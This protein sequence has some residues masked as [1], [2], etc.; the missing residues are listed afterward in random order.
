MSE[1][2]A[3]PIEKYEMAGPQ[4]VA[5]LRRVVEEGLA[6]E[7]LTGI[8]FSICEEYTEPPEHLRQPGSA[9]IGIYLRIQNGNFE[10]GDHPID[11]TFKIVGDYA[12]MREY[13]LRPF[14]PT[15]LDPE[16]AALRQRMIEDGKMRVL[17]PRADSPPTTQ[18]NL[19][20]QPGAE[21]PAVISRLDLHNRA[22]EWTA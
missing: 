10:V 6:G 22:R 14:S 2:L 8:D 11:A 9:T 13:A 15:R 12:A 17:G 20:Q 3:E 5:K 19:H 4:W 7:D 21:W 1:P 16:T 18:L